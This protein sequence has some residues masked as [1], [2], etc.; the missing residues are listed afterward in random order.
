MAAR[1]AI[2]EPLG[3]GKRAFRGV[4]T[5]SDG[6]TRDVVIKRAL[7]NLTKNQKFVAMFLDELRESVPL[8]HAN[9]VETVD[10]AKTPDGAY[11]I[12][13]EYVDGTDLKTFVAR[14]KDIARHQALHVLIECCRGLAHAHALDVVHRDV[15]PRGILLGTKGEVKVVDFG[16]AKA[17]T[18]LESSDAGIVKG[19][20]SYLSPEAAS[21]LE[22]D[23]RMDVFAAGI[24]L[25]ELLAGRPLF[26]GETDYQ[27]VMLVRDAHVPAIEALDPA[28]DAIVRKA[29]ARDAAARFRSA[30]AFGDALAEYAASRGIE[31]APS[32][33]AK[34]VRDVKFEVDCERSATSTDPGILARL[35]DDVR[36]MVSILD[37]SDRPD[38]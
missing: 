16:L 18:Q 34:L 8:R 21:S 28:L 29:L 37:D 2:T 14:R 6:R 9:V 24:V 30:T 17:N 27:T 31:R 26:V 7:P 36:R 13:T 5:S 20:F 19:R 35:Q 11:F 15:S 3:R 1:Y 33:T 23:H 10:I 12:V 4:A 22:L 38:I 25:W 32:E